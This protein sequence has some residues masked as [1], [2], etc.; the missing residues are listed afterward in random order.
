LRCKGRGLWSGI[1]SANCASRLQ[2]PRDAEIN[3]ENV[4]SRRFQQ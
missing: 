2:F 4:R 1:P 3:I